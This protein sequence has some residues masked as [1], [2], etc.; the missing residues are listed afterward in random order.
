MIYA[1][2]PLSFLTEPNCLTNPPINLPAPNTA[3]PTGNPY[4]VATNPEPTALPTFP[5]ALPIC[6]SFVLFNFGLILLPRKSVAK[7]APPI[8]TPLP[9][10]VL[11]KFVPFTPLPTDSFKLFNPP[12]FCGN[13]S[14]DNSASLFVKFV[15]CCAK[16]VLSNSFPKRGDFEYKSNTFCAKSVVVVQLDVGNC[17]INLSDITV[18]AAAL[19]ASFAAFTAFIDFVIV[20]AKSVNLSN[21]LPGL[22]VSCDR[23]PASI[24]FSPEGV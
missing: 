20:L 4:P 13:L 1:E 7:S 15:R 24:C 23:D 5:I 19:V 16:L 21:A 3:K 18:P 17:D 6:A 14:V 22:T 11:R 12:V 9:K 10:P 2:V 8:T